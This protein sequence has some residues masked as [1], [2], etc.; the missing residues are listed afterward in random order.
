M[1]VRKRCAALL[2]TCIT[3]FLTLGSLKSAVGSDASPDVESGATPN[4]QVVTTVAQFLALPRMPTKQGQP[5]HLRAVVTYN[6]PQWNMFQ[7]QDETGALYIPPF[8]RQHEAKAGD[9]VMI[10]GVVVLRD[11]SL[12][13]DCK[14]MKVLEHGVFPKARV[15]RGTDLMKGGLGGVWVETEGI[16]R[17]TRQDARLMLTLLLDG[18]RFQVLVLNHEKRDASRLL[19]ATVRVRG[20]AADNPHPPGR[21]PGNAPDLFVAGMKQIDIV[22]PPVGDPAKL[23]V[24][25]I[26]T[27][28]K[29]GLKAAA[30]GGRIHLHGVVS[31]SLEDALFIQDPTGQMKVLTAEAKSLAVDDRI[32]VQGFLAVNS[33]E[34]EVE[35]A[36]V[37]KTLRPTPVVQTPSAN[38]PTNGPPNLNATL[39]ESISEVVELNATEARKGHPVRFKAVATYSDPE[40]G[41]L[42]VQD[43]TGGVFV[44]NK[45]RTVIRAGEEVE[46]Q[47]TAITGSFRP[48]V[49]NATL[50]VLGTGGLP[51]PHR[52]PVTDLLTGGYDCERVQVEGVARSLTDNWGR[53]TLKLIAA[54]GSFEITVPGF[55]GNPMPTNYLG[56]KLQV[57]GVCTMKQNPTGQSRGVVLN[58]PST[59]DIVVVEMAPLD[60]FS[61]A[62]TQVRDL[63]RYKPRESLARRSKVRGVVTMARPGRALYV[64]DETGGLLAEISGTN[65]IETGQTV[66]IVGYPEAGSFSPKLQDAIWRVVG[67]GEMPKPTDLRAEH[68]LSIRTNDMELVRIDARLLEDVPES[69]LPYLVLQDGSVIFVA[70]LDKIDSRRPLPTLRSGSLLRV[71]GVCAIQPGISEQPRSFQI[72]L[73]SSDDVELLQSPPFLT[74]RYVVALAGLLALATVIISIWVLTLRRKVRQQT[75][76]V[77]QKLGQEAALERRYRELFE[78]ASDVIFT[79]DF[80]GAWL[81]LNRE[82]ERVFGYTKGEIEKITAFDLIV[83]EHHERIRNMIQ[84]L[85]SGNPAAMQEVD[86]IDRR[87]QRT[88]LEVSACLLLVDDKPGGLVCIARNVTERKHAEEDRTRLEAQVRQAQKMEAIGTLAGGIAHDFNNILGII[89]PYTDLARVDAGDNPS[90]QESLSQVAA[91]ANR[92]TDLVKQIL[93]FSRRAKYEKKPIFLKPVV[94]EVL[95]MLRS[96]IPSTVEIVDRIHPNV[97]RVSADASQIHQV[98]MNLC[99]NAS[100]AMGGRTGRIEVELDLFLADAEFVR[101]HPEAQPGRYA[102]LVVSDTGHGIDSETLKHIF[103]PFFSTKGPGEGTGLGL[104]VVHGIVKAHQGSI[105]VYSQPGKGTVFTLLFPACDLPETGTEAPAKPV[106]MPRGNGERILYVDDETVIAAIAKKILVRGGYQVTTHTDPRDALDEF[107]KKPLD[108]DLVITDLTM[109]HMTGTDLAKRLLEV[110]PG[111]P[112]ILATGFVGAL[113]HEEIRKQGLWEMIQKP[114]APSELTKAIERALRKNGVPSNSGLVDEQALANIPFGRDLP[115]SCSSRSGASAIGT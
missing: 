103:E 27:L 56:A 87:Q 20:I 26:S 34:L 55:V 74:V 32:S 79:I 33:G 77:R 25:P 91:A 94:K 23:P 83:P 93:T 30:S 6:D 70:L 28:L 29:S 98:L 113:T 71:T 80:T 12:R 58:V 100:H 14:G 45:A 111:M 110:R 78:N 3:V 61:I 40:W 24:T 8:A 11:G 65:Q 108:Y 52:V 42:F 49:G 10:E 22:A 60:P 81:S 41:I 19:D 54:S 63:L 99:T 109:P 102:K 105:T 46:I 21:L 97:P 5:I 37:E 51:E 104:A 62:V 39:L 82:A 84:Q 114:V 13:V 31:K 96:T 59:N 115:T 17:A 89:I 35:D 107:R 64:Q 66:E 112:I 85:R 106:E 50:K 7:C 90:V 101:D 75:D 92:A 68:I 15:V 18:E 76:L 16:V 47:G 4:E 57:W 95:K 67:K 36:T 88:T 38:P 1:A 2:G 69:T 9:S 43:A 44:E 73:R 48:S 72:L 53:V 86:I